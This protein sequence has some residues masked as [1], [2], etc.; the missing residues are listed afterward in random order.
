MK[1]SSPKFRAYRLT[2]KEED[3]LKEIKIPRTG[4]PS[5]ALNNKRFLCLFQGVLLEDFLN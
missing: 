1:L 5:C 3:F 2:G 4:S